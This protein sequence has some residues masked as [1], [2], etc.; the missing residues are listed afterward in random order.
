MLALTAAPVIAQD[1]RPPG[2]PPPPPAKDARS[3]GA[4]TKTD[5]KPPANTPTTSARKSQSDLASKTAVFTSVSKTDDSLKTA[6]NAHALADALKQT[7][8]AGAFTGT[9]SRIFEPRGNALAI[10]N[11]DADYRSALTAVVRNENFDQFPDL[12][13]L[14]NK[15]VLVTGKF[16]DYRGAAQI[17]LTN[18]AQIKLVR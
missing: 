15:T 16:T 7:N 1:D 11:F 9:V 3:D 18:S 4:A 5:E 12:K 10:L 6:L 8:S 13:T 14:T 2:T 17:V